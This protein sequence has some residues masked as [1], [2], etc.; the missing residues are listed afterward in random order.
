MN[1]DSTENNSF[2][3][4]HFYLYNG[5]YDPYAYQILN[6]HEFL[7]IMIYLYYKSLQIITHHWIVDNFLSMDV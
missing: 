2:P 4:E 7:N 5:N 6:I 3:C 1:F